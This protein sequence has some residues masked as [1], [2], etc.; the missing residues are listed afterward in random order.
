MSAE[1]L[2]WNHSSLLDSIADVTSLRD[3]EGGDLLVSGNVGQITDLLTHALVDQLNLMIEPILL[4]AGKRIFPLDGVASNPGVVLARAWLAALSD[5]C[6]C[7]NVFTPSKLSTGTPLAS[8]ATQREVIPRST[9][10]GTA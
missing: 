7:F 6:A 1:D 9:P 3:Q 2:T 10:T 4:G 8:A 5:A